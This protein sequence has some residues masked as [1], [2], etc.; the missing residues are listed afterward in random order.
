MG[1]G[2]LGSYS[3][4]Y[5]FKSSGNT[6]FHAF[7]ILFVGTDSIACNETR[8]LIENF[9]RDLAKVLYLKINNQGWKKLFVEKH[10]AQLGQ[11]Q[12]TY[13][14][15]SLYAS[16][17]TEMEGIAI[18]FSRI[19]STVAFITLYFPN[20]KAKYLILELKSMP[21]LSGL[22]SKQIKAK[23]ASTTITTTTSNTNTNHRT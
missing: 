3:K 20:N 8:D 23:P 6:E 18:V 15:A 7:F 11:R 4:L 9:V 22:I 19:I 10:E 16:S 1:S 2:A 17:K 13:Y 5:I 12:I 21:Y 14:V